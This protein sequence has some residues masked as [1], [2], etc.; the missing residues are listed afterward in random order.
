MTKRIIL[1]S[2]L[3]SVVCFVSAYG[4]WSTSAT[5][6]DPNRTFSLNL[7]L[8]MS[9]VPFGRTGSRTKTITVFSKSL[10]L[11]KIKNI[12]I[13]TESI[14]VN[15]IPPTKKDSWVKLNANPDLY[16]PGDIYLEYTGDTLKI[17]VKENQK[18][19][20]ASELTGETNRRGLTLDVP[21]TIDVV[22]VKT[23]SGDLLVEKLTLGKLIFKSA[24]GDNVITGSNF[25]DVE[26]YSV[27]GDT[28]INGD[29]KKLGLKSTSGDLALQ[30]S[31]TSPE[32]NVVTVSGDTKV[33]FSKPADTRVS[34]SS[35]SG[36]LNLNSEDIDD[37]TIGGVRIDKTVGS[38]KGLIQVKSVSGDLDIK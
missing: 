10:N 6:N 22:S 19:Y 4:F 27:S 13:N 28:K 7:S 36:G 29:L 11:D 17:S 2:T 18:I 21:S 31:N 12:E 25:E 26:V 23:V 20:M 9:N 8:P 14:D 33:T 1:I 3:V 5:A 37:R 38:G 16:G 35:V 32:L 24:S 30:L 15:L 34:F